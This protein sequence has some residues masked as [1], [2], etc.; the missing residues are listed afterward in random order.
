MTLEEAAM[1][2]IEKEQNQ[3]GY[4]ELSEDEVIALVECLDSHAEN[5]RGI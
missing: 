2:L 3:I 1:L 4:F 5:M